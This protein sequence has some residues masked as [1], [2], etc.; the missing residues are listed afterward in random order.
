MR[1]H[2]FFTII[3][4]LFTLFPHSLEA[5]HIISII[6]KEPVSNTGIPYKNESWAD[7]AAQKDVSQQKIALQKDTTQ[8]NTSLT[9]SR[10]VRFYTA[11]FGPASLQNVN[12]D[13]LA[14]NFW[15]GY[16]WEPVNYASI[17]ASG[18]ITTDFSNSLLLGA[19]LGANLY[20]FTTDISPYIGGEMGF[21][22]CRG[23]NSNMAGISFGGIIGTQFFRFSDTQLLFELKAQVLLDKT[24]NEKFPY[25]FLARIGLLF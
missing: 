1:L 7:S 5:G 24:E 2:I 16:M 20:P 12:S 15:G 9:K 3:C 4:L 13:E 14:Y 6:K 17:R 8:Q 25:S 23:D 11:G 18:D 19:S 21:G 10:A 22:Y